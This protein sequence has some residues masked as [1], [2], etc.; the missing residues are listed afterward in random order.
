MRKKLFVLIQISASQ[1]MFRRLI[2][3]C[4]RLTFSLITYASLYLNNFLARNYR[5]FSLTGNPLL[6]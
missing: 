4:E 5:V 6:N 3:F 2:N 1:S